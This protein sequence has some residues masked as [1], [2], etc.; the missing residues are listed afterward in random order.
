MPVYQ[1]LIGFF[2]PL[3]AGKFHSVLFIK[4]FDLSV[5]D[6]R[7]SRHG[8]QKQAD[9]EVFI[10]FSELFGGGF[11]VGIVHEI[12]VPFKNVGIKLQRFPNQIT[13]FRVFFFFEH[14]HESAVVNAVHSESPDKITFHHPERFRQ[15][16]CVG[17]F[18]RHSINHFPPKLLRHSFI[19]INRQH[20]VFGTRRNISALPGSRE[21]QPLNVTLGKRHC[22]VK[23]DNRKIAG[24]MKNHLN[25]CFFC[26]RIQKINLRR[27]VPRQTGPVVSMV[28]VTVF[29]FVFIV[30]A[31]YNGTVFF[32]VILIFNL[33]RN[34]RITTQIGSVKVVLRIRILRQLKKPIRMDTDPS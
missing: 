31:K 24:H 20:S 19:E 17:N 7:Q 18:R 10:A 2:V 16:Q 12:D 27:I 23:T 14:I 28:N 25:D 33:N 5:T 32:A 9:S 34:V 3:R 6:H 21:P 29:I 11:F 13:V 26:F 1:P 8:R 30:A 15:Q 22:R 4:S